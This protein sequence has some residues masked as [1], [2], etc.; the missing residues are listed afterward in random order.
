MST[1]VYIDFN[2]ATKNMIDDLVTNFPYIDHFKLL[3]ASFAV[4]RGV[5]KKLP[6]KMFNKYVVAFYEKEI[7][8]K[9]ESFFMSDAFSSLFWQ[10][11]VDMIK[12]TWNTLENVN[13]DAVWNHV[14]AL[15]ALNKRCVDHRKKK[16]DDDSSD[17]TI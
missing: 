8:S 12:A 7:K 1:Q 5:N 4:M 10:S 17:E 15:V 16:H 6:H 2:I 3:E 13:K 9:D 11:F 14:L